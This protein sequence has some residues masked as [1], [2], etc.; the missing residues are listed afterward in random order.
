MLETPDGVAPSV[1]TPVSAAILAPVSPFV[2]SNP[3]PRLAAAPSLDWGSPSQIADYEDYLAAMAA[4]A[5]A[6]AFAARADDHADE[7]GP[8]ERFA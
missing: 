7:M 4:E 2:N 6:T 8:V 5:D 3:F 1:E